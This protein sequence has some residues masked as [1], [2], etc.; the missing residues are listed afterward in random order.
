MDTP[1]HKQDFNITMVYP[2]KWPTL[3]MQEGESLFE[4]ETQG[5]TDNMIKDWVKYFLV[6][7]T[8]VFI[9]TK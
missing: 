1:C 3:Y 5:G 8:L 2:Y 4:E 6:G 7:F 9:E